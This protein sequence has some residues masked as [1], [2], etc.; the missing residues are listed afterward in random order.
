MPKI[1]DII[2]NSQISRMET[3]ILISYLLKKDRTF[4]IS[5]HTKE[6]SD[7]LY[8]KYLK[9][10]KKRLDNWPIAYL[11]GIKY[12][13][14]YKFKVN[15]NVLVPRQETEELID[16]SL[17]ILNKRKSSQIIIDIGTGSGAIIIT[18][19]KELIK[20]NNRLY[21]KSIFYGLDISNKALSVAKDNSKL[22]KVAKK[23]NFHKSDLLNYFT[24][25]KNN[26]EKK[27]NKL[28]NIED[29]ILI[30]ANL[31]YLK[32]NQLKEESIKHEPKLALY[33]KQ[34]GLDHYRRLLIEVKNIE[35]ANDRKIDIFCEINPKQRNELNK[36]V[37][38]HLPNFKTKLHKDLSSKYRFLQIKNY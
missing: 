23:I 5:H 9:L 38:K 37:K 8:K 34:N 28:N 32:P 29:D 36:L 33:S 11:T 12:F 30:L 1:K 14:N 2:S 20:I 35:N 26:K 25:K 31:P 7:S 22:N 21:K 18:M 17:D 3:E 15:K 16:L 27:E 6:V 4:I 24:S 10:E 13:Y 19:A